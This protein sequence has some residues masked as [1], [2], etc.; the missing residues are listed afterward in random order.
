MSSSTNRRGGR[1]FPFFCGM[2]AASGHRSEGRKAVED[3]VRVSLERR[4]CA[5]RDFAKEG[6]GQIGLPWLVNARLLSQFVNER[7]WWGGRSWFLVQAFADG[8]VLSNF[9]GQ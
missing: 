7:S 2:S 9:A 6:S 8:F 3:N 5:N 4:A 1:P